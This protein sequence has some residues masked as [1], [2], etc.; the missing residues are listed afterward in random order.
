MKM[1]ALFPPHQ[2]FYYTTQS[3]ERISKNHEALSKYSS[4]ITA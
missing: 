2:A 3:E 1:L 4:T